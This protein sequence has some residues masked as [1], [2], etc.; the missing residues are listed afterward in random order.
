MVRIFQIFCLAIGVLAANVPSSLV[1]GCMCQKGT[2]VQCGASCGCCSSELAGCCGEGTEK[3]IANLCSCN[4][5]PSTDFVGLAVVELKPPVFFYIREIIFA[6][7]L[8]IRSFRM[9]DTPIA[10][11]PPPDTLVKRYCVYLI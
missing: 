1:P 4:V 2:A 5:K 10:D 7:P 9:N 6:K 3:P 11:K 8:E